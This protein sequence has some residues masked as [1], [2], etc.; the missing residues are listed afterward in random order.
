M[1]ENLEIKIIN[2]GIK[3]YEINEEVFYEEMDG[4][5][6]FFVT[7]TDKIIVMNETSYFLWQI[8]LESSASFT[9]LTIDELINKVKQKFDVSKI[10]IESLK[11]DVEQ[12][13]FHFEDEDFIRTVQ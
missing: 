7:S 6:Y 10:S 8:I 11:K 12:A 1:E 9:E 2:N 4:Q 3:K 5:G 13:I